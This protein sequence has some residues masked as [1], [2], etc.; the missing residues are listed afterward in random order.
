MSE[1]LGAVRSVCDTESVLDRRALGCALICALVYLPLPA[2]ARREATFGY[3]I[4][5]VWTAAVRLV[6]V[7]LECVIGEKDR[8]DGYFFFE[9]T[10]RGK[11]YPGS[12]ELVSLQ[13]SGADHV[14]VIVQVPA[15]PAYVEAMILDRLGRKLEQEFGPPKAAPAT[16]PGSKPD[17]DDA[18]K[19]DKD[20][21]RA[22]NKPPQ[23][24]PR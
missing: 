9:Y 22:P 21:A 11:S 12:V 20:G 18:A 1:P 4:S 8:D 3:P 19:A 2:A 15:M 13:D 23:A 24:A 14:R 17:D 6:R 10:D 16:K 5:R 7:D